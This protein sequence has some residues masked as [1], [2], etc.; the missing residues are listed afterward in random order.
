MPISLNDYNKGLK[1]EDA[2]ILS[3]LEQKPYQAYSFSDLVTKTG[4]LWGDVVNGLVLNLRLADL[5]EKGLI[6]SKYIGN[7][8]YYISSKAY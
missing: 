5:K 2:E 7:N 6:K 8:V 4:N 3:V 1:P